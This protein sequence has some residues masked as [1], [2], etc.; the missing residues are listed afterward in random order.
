MAPTRSHF[1]GSCHTCRRRH[2]RCDRERPSCS[3]CRALGV[4]CEG[5]SD[6]MC[7]VSYNEQDSDVTDGQRQGMRRHLYSEKSRL[8]MSLTL[9]DNLISDSIDATLAEIDRESQ[10]LEQ[11]ES[12]DVVPLPAG[13]VV[14][15]TGDP[16]NTFLP[17][18]VAPAEMQN[19]G[20]VTP[21]T[22]P[23]RCMDDFLHWSDILDVEFNPTDFLTWPASSTLDTINSTSL[24][25]NTPF[26]EPNG[27]PSITIPHSLPSEPTPN[28]QRHLSWTPNS[29]LNAD[30]SSQAASD[31]LADAPFLLKHLQENV[32]P[33]M[34]AMPLGRKS[35][36]TMLNMPA[37]VVTL[38]DV[39]FLSAQNIR[40][41]RLAN[42]YSLIACSALHLTLQPS[43]STDRPLEHWQR[44]TNQAFLQAKEQVQLSL[45]NELGPPTKAKYKDQ[46]MALCALT[47]FTIMSGQ[48]EHARC[49][50][51]D[52]ER[53]IRI[54]GFVKRKISQKARLLHHVYTWHR[55]VGESTYVL[56]DY[57]PSKTF[58]HALQNNFKSSRPAA[59][60]DPTSR[61]DSFMRLEINATDRDLNIDERKDKETSLKDI[62]LEDSRNFPE[63]LYKQIYGIPETWLSL[64]SQTTRLANV[65]E[66]FRHARHTVPN[67]SFDAWDTLH[68]RSVRLEYMICSLN[69]NSRYSPNDTHDETDNPDNDTNA[70]ST[71][72][73]THLL[74]ALNAALLIFFYRRIRNLHLQI[75]QH[76]VDDVLT[77]LEEFRLALPPS[78]Q[79]I[80]LGS[81]WPAFIAGCEANGS[82]RREA[83]IRW[84]DSAYAS[85][86]FPALEVAKEVMRGVWKAQDG[87]GEGN[88]VRARGEV[89]R[90]WVDVAKEEKVWPMLC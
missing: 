47:E 29:Q 30:S 3:K 81:I 8:S 51:L 78:E 14:E 44:V 15:I 19:F 38:G 55:I 24:L 18:P 65:M 88:S 27:A 13:E 63:T 33:L 45:K 25:F 36:W 12:N 72:P 58:L 89:C 87:G 43:N 49:L 37:A 79:I 69:S 6:D 62:H 4:A 66:M 64:L 1:L 80:G 83:V 34:V 42:L 46:M 53:L 20:S 75:L 70:T 57:T 90:T 35:P 52:T 56:H 77:G 32:A 31:V 84:L 39:T 86:R 41:A 16:T 28:S 22:D 9:R 10:G 82:T 40:H 60:E 17:V 7:W 21:L 26:A 48:P 74:R 76:H 2:V 54:R 23:L 85:C 73:R 68:R 67:L 71:T 50:L 11:T 5:F 59:T 61:R